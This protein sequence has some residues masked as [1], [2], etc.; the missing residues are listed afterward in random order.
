MLSLQQYSKN[1]QLKSHLNQRSSNTQ[2]K[3]LATTLCQF[4]R[5]LGVTHNFCNQRISTPSGLLI[6]MERKVQLLST[7]VSWPWRWFNNVCGMCYELCKRLQKVL[8]DSWGSCLSSLFHDIHLR[9]KRWTVWSL[10]QILLVAHS[11]SEFYGKI[12]YSQHFICMITSPTHKSSLLLGQ[13]TPPVLGSTE[14]GKP[15]EIKSHF[16][17]LATITSGWVF[18]LGRRRVKLF[19]KQ[20]KK[21]TCTSAFLPNICSQIPP[22]NIHL[23]HI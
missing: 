5:H 16:F 19:R 23:F 18:I 13:K 4:S 6:T 12:F 1:T 20:S 22:M 8:I 9:A 21:T 15:T 2:I 14:T 17:L 7:S 10:W 11:W 3:P